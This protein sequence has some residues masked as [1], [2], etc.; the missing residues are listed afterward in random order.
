M[1][2][3]F[4]HVPEKEY[5][6]RVRKAIGDAGFQRQRF[7]VTLQVST[8][9]QCDDILNALARLPGVHQASVSEDF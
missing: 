7:H 8:E 9:L 5:K 3:T 4:A 6:E 2:D 1:S